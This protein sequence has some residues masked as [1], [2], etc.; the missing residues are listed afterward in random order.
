MF[1]NVKLQN[2][3]SFGEIEFD[4]S[5]KNGCPK[6]LAV[7][8]GENGAG[9]SNLMSAF[10]FLREILSTMNVRDMYEELL[11]HKA[12]FADE[13]MESMIRQQI[14]S[15]LRDMAAIVNDYRMVGSSEPI[16]AEYEFSL[17]GSIG[18]YRIELNGEE[19]V[20]EKLE[21][22][23]SKRRGIY[24]ECSSQ[25]I[26]INSGIVKSKELLGDIK[27]AAKRFWGKHSLFAVVLHEL[28]DKSKSYGEDN[29]SDN[30]DRVLAMISSLSCY[31]GIGTKRWDRLISNLDVLESADMGDLPLSKEK[32]LDIAERIFTQFFSAI[33]SDVR[34]VYYDRKYNDKT[35]RYALMFEKL[36][37]GEYR[38]IEFSRESTGNH[39]VLRVLCYLLT[40]CMGG[41]VV[42][43][44]ADSG[45]HDYLFKKLFDEISPYIDGQVIM[46]T[47]NTMLMETNF[48]RDST[49]ILSEKE[50][51]HKEIKTVSN[52]DKRTYFNN[53]IRN[54]YLNGEYRGLP[55][56]APIDF[57]LIIKE[58]SDIIDD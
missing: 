41:I 47:H 36:V 55:K 51:G 17:L 6:N 15:D 22:L 37:A 46:T 24:F 25:G 12:F 26:Y 7:V 49:Y 19:I 28:V 35:I 39:Q 54:K 43:D 40:A 50:D 23:L 38:H 44:E 11:N 10:V 52:Y 42:I 56:V 9:K 29:I 45:V 21:Y 31:I 4:L 53:N 20:H 3:R 32:E 13:N 27:A 14:K 2:F 5:N 33:N 48:S 58:I 30:F 18:K 1:T 8:F 57:P 16:V 34:K